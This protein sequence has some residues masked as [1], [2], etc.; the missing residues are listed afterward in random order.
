MAT[1]GTTNWALNRDQLISAA[2]RKLGVLPSGGTPS[3]DQV[4]DADV[5]LNAIVKAFQA[6]GMQLWKV[7]STTFTVSSGDNSY[8]I[9]PARIIDAPTPLRVI[10]AFCTQADSPA[11]EMNLYTRYDFNL[12]PTDATGIPVNFYYQPLGDYGTLKLWPT[13]DDDTTEITIHYVGMLEDMTA[14]GDDFDFPSYWMNALIFTLAWSLAPE[15]GIPPTDRGLLQKE[16]QYWHEYAL[17][18]GSEEG[19]IFFQPNWIGK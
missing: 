19:S 16:S 9:G 13:P 11:V 7:A 12:L 18:M 3:A 14:A 6:D 15:Y 4:S 2:L 1:S 5:S 17:S 8:N 10:Q